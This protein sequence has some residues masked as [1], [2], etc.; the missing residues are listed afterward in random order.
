MGEHRALAVII[1]NNNLSTKRANTDIP[2][3]R[4][5]FMQA[6]I[7]MRAGIKTRPYAR[8]TNRFLLD[9]EVNFSG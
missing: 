2:G 7:L 5:L 8:N 1:A 4:S 9:S 6:G 3:V